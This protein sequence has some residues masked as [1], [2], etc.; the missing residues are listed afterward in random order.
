MKSYAHIGDHKFLKIRTCFIRSH[1]PKPLDSTLIYHYDIIKPVWLW[2]EKMQLVKINLFASTP[3]T[4]VANM[5]SMLP[6]HRKMLI[7]SKD[8]DKPQR[9]GRGCITASMQNRVLIYHL[10]VFYTNWI[11]CGPICGQNLLLHRRQSSSCVSQ[12][13]HETHSTGQPGS[14]TPWFVRAENTS[15]YCFLVFLTSAD[16]PFL[17]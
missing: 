1:S 8:A 17:F 11:G 12:Q 14:I 5:N 7:F 10:F 15:F 16:L 4:T 3:F 9:N 6:G 13:T 2:P